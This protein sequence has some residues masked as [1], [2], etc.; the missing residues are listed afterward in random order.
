M[1]SV[2][3][4]ALPRS[5]SS[6]TYLDR[7]FNLRKKLRFVYLFIL[8]GIHA[9]LVWNPDLKILRGHDLHQFLHQE[10]RLAD[11]RVLSSLNFGVHFCDRIEDA[12]DLVRDIPVV[13]GKPSFVVRVSPEVLDDG[14]LKLKETL[15]HIPLGSPPALSEKMKKGGAQ[16]KLTTSNISSVYILYFA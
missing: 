5:F 1:R 7:H 4:K 2:G 15:H 3:F 8:Y 9:W 16:S 12:A 10:G 11:V 14:L 6:M 13:T